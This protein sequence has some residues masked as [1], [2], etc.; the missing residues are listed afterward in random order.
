MGGQTN[1]YIPVAEKRALAAAA[2][3][4][5]AAAAAQD[6]ADSNPETLAARD[7]AVA[8][9]DAAIAAQVIAEGQVVPVSGVEDSFQPI[10]MDDVDNVL[11]WLKDGVID[12]LG[13]GETLTGAITTEITDTLETQGLGNESGQ[14]DEKQ[15]LVSDG[16]NVLVWL[17]NGLLDAIGAGPTLLAD[18]RDKAQLPTAD[19]Y[20]PS[21]GGRWLRKHRANVINLVHGSPSAARLHLWCSGDSWTERELIPQAILDDYR[22][23]GVTY[24]ASGWQGFGGTFRLDEDSLAV[25]SGTRLDIQEQGASDGGQ[26][27]PDGFRMTFSA[28]DTTARIVMNATGRTARFYYKLNGATFSYQVDAGS[29]V[30]VTGSSAG[31]TGYTEID[32]GSEGTHEVIITRPTATNALECYGFFLFSD[33]SGLTL[34]S[35]GDGGSTMVHL[36]GAVVTAAA[37]YILADIDGLGMQTTVRLCWLTNDSRLDNTVAAT[38]AAL[39]TIIGAY[40]DGFASCEG[41]FVCPPANAVSG[42]SAGIAIDNYIPDLLA[43]CKAAEFDFVNLW[44]LLPAHAEALPLWTEAATVDTLHFT[45]EGGAAPWIAATERRLLN[46]ETA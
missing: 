36:A 43:V 25:T 35:A 34:S 15:I 30:P 16:S 31:G 2:M 28:A 9:R 27:A 6:V 5:A 45:A 26:Y 23:Q 33:A 29:V 22:A 41:Y 42:I 18:I 20:V 32:L 38:A 17:I 14:G 1:S 13:F 12:A 19:K 37:Q 10:V 40:Q 8:A 44:T 7:E 46:W 24:V 3:A 21:T 4:E 39:E 11:V